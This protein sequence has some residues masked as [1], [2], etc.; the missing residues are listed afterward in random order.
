M[1]CEL[2]IFDD[3]NMT[4]YKNDLFIYLPSSRRPIL[5]E[6][7]TP[8]SRPKELLQ[9]VYAIYEFSFREGARLF[10]TDVQGDGGEVQV[11]VHIKTD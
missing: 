2:R 10:V 8:S 6:D 9:I 5:S 1:R 3:D 4:D 7:S 11:G